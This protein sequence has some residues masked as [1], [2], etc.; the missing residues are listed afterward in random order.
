[1]QIEGFLT[2]L[3]WFLLGFLIAFVLVMALFFY[4]QVKQVNNDLQTHRAM[5]LFLPVQVISKI[6]TLRKLVDEIISKDSDSSVAGK[7]LSSASSRSPRV[8]PA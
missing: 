5:L 7:S 1:M 8:A 4:P 3:V 2:F 6:R